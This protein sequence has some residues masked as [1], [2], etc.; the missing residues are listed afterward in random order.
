MNTVAR[1]AIIVSPRQ[2]F[3]DWL[4]QRS[5]HRDEPVSL[6]QATENYVFTFLVPEFTETNQFDDILPM[7]KRRLFENIAKMFEPD[8]FRWPKIY[9]EN[10]FDEWFKISF[11][12][13][14][15][16]VGG[17]HMFNV[18]SPTVLSTGTQKYW[19]A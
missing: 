4:N 9:S 3:V 17:D 11:S 7:V 10:I 8:R 19:E 1:G 15:H 14:V 16:D 12:S 2:P 18:F 6:E 5:S 13:F